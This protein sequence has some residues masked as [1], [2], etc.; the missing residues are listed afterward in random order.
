[1]D[2]KNSTNAEAAEILLRYIVKDWETRDRKMFPMEINSLLM[3]AQ[4]LLEE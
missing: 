3:A 1:M 4:E 2:V